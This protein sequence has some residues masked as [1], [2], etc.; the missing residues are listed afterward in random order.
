[1]KA[2][3][4]IAASYKYTLLAL[5]LLGVVSGALMTISHL[6]LDHRPLA[7]QSGHTPLATPS[8]LVELRPDPLVPPPLTGHW[9]P[10][11]AESFNEQTL[12][13]SRWNTC[14]WWDNSPLGCDGSVANGELQRYLPGNVTVH[15]GMLDIVARHESYSTDSKTYQ[16]TSGIITTE[17][18]FV[19]RYGYV[20]ARIH[21][22]D[23][24]GIWPAFW[25]L[26]QDHL[27]KNEIDI[28]EILCDQPDV[29]NTALH[30]TVNGRHA[31]VGGTY[32][33]V[34]F[35]QGYHVIAVDW[36]PHFIT[37]YVDGKPFYYVSSAAEIPQTDMYL[38]LNS[39]VGG[40]WSGNPDRSTPFPHH[41]SIDWVQVWQ[42]A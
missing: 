21:L 31:S 15:G 1:M 3:V 18:K 13:T 26:P 19:F 33:G 34:H 5:A 23:G 32:R 40:Y 11:F 12:D 8:P 41:Y 9:S 30:F 17:G 2:I 14:F 39:A 6:R 35:D 27:A 42:H 24:K 28:A 7:A 20:E 36:E 4:H 10:V 25:M 29:V 22:T 38:L 37:W 16:Y